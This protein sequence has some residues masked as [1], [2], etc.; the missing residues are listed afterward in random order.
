MRVPIYQVDA[1]TR[2]AFGGNPAAVCPLDRPMPPALMQAIA[3]ENNL[4][5]TAFLHGGDGR[6]AIRWFTPATE[7][8]LC[9]HATLAAAWV[10]FRRLE[11]GRE[12]VTFDS[13][14]GPLDATREGD[15]L[16][17]DFPAIPSVRVDLSAA[18]NAAFGL[19]PLEAWEGSSLMLLFADEGTIRALRPNAGAIA[20]LHGHAVI[21]TA[22]GRDC[23]FVSRFFA[24]NVG[25]LE[26]PV[27]G[28]AHAQL[29]PWWSRRLGRTALAAR[30]LSERGGEVACELA[31]PRV[32]MGGDAVLYL[33]GAIEVPDA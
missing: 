1:F 32:R 3:A 2:R 14:S 31:G 10:V 25:I 17:L 9:G 6:Y 28:A 8:P 23:D 19:A 20:H 26:D 30:Q 15:R 7:V 29:T 22:P 5:E 16:V 13:A 12:R 11:P 18:M 21:A 24:P 27:T 33:E 4:S